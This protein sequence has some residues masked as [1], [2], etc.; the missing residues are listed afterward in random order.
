MRSQVSQREPAGAGVDMSELQVHHCITPEQCRWF[1]CSVRAIP[2]NKVLVQELNRLIG[3][4]ML[5][6]NFLIVFGSLSEFPGGSSFCP[7]CGHP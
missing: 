1:L 3:F 5:T 6:L 4:D 2:V 7:F